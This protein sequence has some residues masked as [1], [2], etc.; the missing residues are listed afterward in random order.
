M[1]YILI[2][3]AI[4]FLDT[5]IK[6]YMEANKQ[7]GEHQEIL[8]GKVTIQKYYNRGVFLNF[9]EDKKEKVKT[10]SCVIL[11]LFLLLFAIVLPKKGRKLF[12][13][14][15][16]FT[17]G[18]AISNVTDR[19]TR[20]YVVDYFSINYKKLKGVVFNLADMFIFLG[21]VLIMLSTVF[22]TKGKGCSNES[23][24]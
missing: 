3:I 2:V 13:L 21:S 6:D 16:A 8:E 19:F 9:L 12:K 14:G 22:S 15:L 20:G 11:S 7:L 17:L 23:A 1:L 5:K 24:K 4:A 18:G 10:V